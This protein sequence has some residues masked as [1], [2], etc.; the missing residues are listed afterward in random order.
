MNLSQRD[1]ERLR[2]KRWRMNHLY[3]VIN[4]KGQI[5]T[6]KFNAEQ[7]S[8]F[9]RYEKRK[10]RDEY[11]LREN[12]LKDRQIGIT[13]FHCIYNLDEVVWNKG[14]TAVIIAHEREALEKIFRKVRF[15]WE[16][17]PE[18]FRPVAEM[19][20]KRELSF[21]EIGS[22]IYIALKV[23]SGTVHHLHVSEIAYIPEQDELKAGSF[24]SVPKTGDITCETTGNGYNKFYADWVRGK[25]SNL[26][27]NHFFS[28]TQ[29]EDYVSNIKK[30][31]NKYDEY[32]KNCTEEQR[33]WWYITLDGLNG[34]FDLMKQEYPITEDDAWR[35]TGAGIYHDIID[36]PGTLNPIVDIDRSKFPT[37]TDE[38]FRG[39]SIYEYPQK[40]SEDVTVRRGAY[41]LGADTSGG[42]SDSDYSSFFIIETRSRKI[43]AK[44]KE[45][46]VPD[47][48][49]HRI[50]R[51]GS[52]YNNAYCGVEANNHGLTVLTEMRDA[53]YSDL[54]QRERRD[55][56]TN[57]LTME[58][59][60]L[61]TAKSKE[62][63]VD[64]IRKAIRDRDVEDLPESLLTE[65]K[66][67]VQH[68]NGSLG[69]DSG[70]NDDEV[71]AFG[72]T[73]MM[74]RSR[75]YV[76]IKPKISKYFGNTLQYNK[77]GGLNY[78]GRL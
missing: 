65:L 61:T 6:F 64:E 68:K 25:D 46:I 70:C 74:L 53:G 10:K 29:H 35:S 33:N 14:R 55:K 60:W 17:M 34:D 63:L 23:R 42:Y 71:M 3:K 7:E 40:E 8:L 16:S 4:K 54:Y 41:V 31:S 49:A 75:P 13:T 52:E 18:P 32:L 73:L 45:K 2:S 19:D 5:V 1:K 51:W 26:W 30:T 72:I 77:I 27:N 22:N 43:V 36:I 76:D 62:A 39:M 59:G 78:N 28:W 47:L 48:F 20:N 58:M 12:I 57:D 11:G 38:D 56:V 37:L 24:Q 44:F 66:T 50:M 69:A 9:S 67:F 21:N 15:A